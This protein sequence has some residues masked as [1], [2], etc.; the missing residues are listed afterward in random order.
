MSMYGPWEKVS[1]ELGKL[2]GKQKE[3]KEYILN[4]SAKQFQD[5][6]KA[7]IVSRNIHPDGN[8]VS[9]VNYASQ[10]V[11]DKKNANSTSIG[12]PKRIVTDKEF[13]LGKFAIEA[14][15]GLY[16]NRFLGV[17]RNYMGEFQEKVKMIVEKIQ[18][19]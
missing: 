1:L 6:I 8:N 2:P 13:S 19:R 4:E 10:I 14:E 7:Q 15:Y 12:L 18:K 5:G 11:V 17:W 9:S 3:V 16:G